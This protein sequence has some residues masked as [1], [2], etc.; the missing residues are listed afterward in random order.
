M[1][2]RN[3]EKKK[4]NGKMVE[5]TTREFSKFKKDVVAAVLAGVF[6]VGGM[7]AALNCGADKEESP[8]YVASDV[9][10][11]KDAGTDVGVN[12]VCS[13]VNIERQITRKKG[14]SFLISLN[15]SSAYVAEI[16]EIDASSVSMWI[17]NENGTQQVFVTLKNGESRDFTINNTELNITVCSIRPVGEVKDGANS[18]EKTEYMATLE[19]TKGELKVPSADAG[20]PDVLSDAGVDA[21]V[22]GDVS[23][24][25]DAGQDTGVEQL[26]DVSVEEDAGVDVGVEG[27]AEQDAGEQDVS[28]EEDAGVVE[29][30]KDAGTEDTEST[31]A[32]VDVGVEQ[33][34]DASTEDTEIADAEQDVGVEQLEDAGQDAGMVCEKKTECTDTSKDYQLFNNNGVVVIETF[35]QQVCKITNSDCSVEIVEGPIKLT[36]S[37]SLTPDEQAIFCKQIVGDSYPG[38]TTKYTTN[39]RVSGEL[40]QYLSLIHI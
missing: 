18:A 20:Q 14:E 19:T 24:E 21:D 23:V 38:L 32:G 29:E 30:L 7:L 15:D 11:S 16:S 13:S 12:K 2:L 6:T 28:V 33:L 10:T 4:M 31:D 9:S 27:D 22:E 25:Q 36:L 34:E 3:D 1:K 8:V 26:E 40:L 17:Y 5:G 39:D 37:G 35:S